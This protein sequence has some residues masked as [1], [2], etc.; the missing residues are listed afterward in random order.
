MARKQDEILVDLEAALS[1]LKQTTLTGPDLSSIDKLSEEWLKLRGYSVRRPHIYSMKPKNLDDLFKLFYFLFEKNYPGFIVPYNN[2]GHDRKIAKEFV[3][4]RMKAEGIN[5]EL[6]LAQ[7][8]QVIEALFRFKNNFEFDPAPTFGV[9]SASMGWL[10]DKVIGLINKNRIKI[11][12]DRL[13]FKIEEQ[14]KLVEASFDP[15]NK[16]EEIFRRNN[17]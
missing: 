15:S 6:A 17:V 16:L 12:K 5:K 4:S 11:D 1:S 13:V 8:A 9:F 10:V 2:E 3:E 7:C 14:T